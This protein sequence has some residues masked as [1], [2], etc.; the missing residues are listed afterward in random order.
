[1]LDLRILNGVV[2]SDGTTA[3]LDVGI[4]AGRIVE[5]DETGKLGPA[6][7]ELDATGLHV[8]PGAIDV[9]FHCR[10]PSHPERGTFDSE[11]RAA[12][13]GGVTTIF[14]MPVSDPA[15]STPEVFRQRRSLAEREANVNFAIY[16]GAAL[17]A[18][19]AAE[20]AAEGA[21]A[22]K[23]FTLTPAPD[24]EVEFRG[25]WA[26]G[27]PAI[28]DALAAVASTGLPCV[29]H[30]ENEPLISYYESLETDGGVGARPPIVEAVA[31]AQ[32]AAL[33]KEAA[34]RVH[35][36]HVTSRSALDAVR[37]AVAMG[38]AVSAET[39]PQYL[40]LDSGAV[41]RYGGVAKIAPPLRERADSEALWDGLRDGTISLVASDHAPFLV[42][43]KRDV[44]YALA[45]QGLPTVELL[46]PVLLDA[47]VKGRLPLELAVALITSAPARLFGLHPEKGRIAPGSDADLALVS[48]TDVFRPR[49]ESLMTRA[50]GCGIVFGDMSLQAR[51]RKTI[52]NGRLV[53]ADGTLLSPPSGRFTPGRAVAALEPV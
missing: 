35:I 27:E 47:A 41:E 17:S 40:M 4:E 9:H 44:A 48:L 20:M 1:V 34:A 19:A 45:P 38:A 26:S 37:G 6:R 23:L 32:V 42:H 13:A 15:C 43:E 53:Y 3:A 52:V 46:V 10:A 25:L 49:P 51:V 2:V 5:V 21:I 39:C 7:Q 36:A 18:A 14:E 16:S 29:I 33:A 50:A 11:T 12:A 31:I 24:R 8:L 28:L 30:A 22:F